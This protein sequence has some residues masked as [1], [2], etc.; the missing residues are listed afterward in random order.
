MKF[1]VDLNRVEDVKEFVRNAE[2]YD[3]DIM[4]KNQGRTFMVD[5]KSIMGIFSLDLSKPVVVHIENTEV[6]E[7][8]KNDVAKFIV[9]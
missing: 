8:F 4:V 9:V 3:C 5:A 2:N 6:G 7:S 1:I